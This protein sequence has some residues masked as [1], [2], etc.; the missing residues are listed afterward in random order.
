VQPARSGRGPKAAR[1]APVTAPGL[2]LPQ[3]QACLVSSGAPAP[4][5]AA[6]P[7]LPRPASTP[8]P[9]QPLASRAPAREPQLLNAAAALPVPAATPCEGDKPLRPQP[10][11]RRASPAREAV[12]SSLSALAP[13]WQPSSSACIS[14]LASAARQ[15][16]PDRAALPPPQQLQPRRVVQHGFTVAGNGGS[17][18]Q[19]AWGSGGCV[20]SALRVDWSFPRSGSG[21]SLSSL[22]H[23]AQVGSPT[24]ASSYL[25]PSALESVVG[26][27]MQHPRNLPTEDGHWAACA[28]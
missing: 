25:F 10:T 19:G 1:D 9:P 23:R 5:P 7:A 20:P 26:A 17:G 27:P 11:L 18:A 13:T 2:S 4:N 24:F 28:G 12:P 16:E 6:N 21:A 14:G 3:P 15:Q 8:Q 22:V